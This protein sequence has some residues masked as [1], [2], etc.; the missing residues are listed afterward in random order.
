MARWC[1]LRVFL[2]VFLSL[3]CAPQAFSQAWPARPIHWIVPYAPGAGTDTT[4][5]MLV[6]KLSSALGQPIVVENRGGAGGAIGTLAGAKAP[7]DGYT[8]TFASDPPFTINPNLRRLPFDPQ[9]D[10]VAVSLL[11]KVPLVLVVK[12][13]LAAKTVA[14][15][16][17]LAR[18]E[19]GR[20]TV[21]SSGNGSSGHLAGEYFKAVTTTDILHVPYKGQAEAVNDVVAGR[22][23][24]NFSAI[25]NVLQL[26]ASGRLRIIAIASTARFSGLPE[27]PTIAESGYPGFEIAAFHGLLM[28]AGTPEPIVTRVN[29]EV[30]KLLRSPEVAARMFGLGFFPV[31]GAPVELERLIRADTEKWG[32]LISS[33][34]IKAE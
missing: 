17:A 33:S 26:A 24:M 23:D 3:A 12:P 22:V 8:W 16:V 5:R 34:G 6:D 31:G 32:K 18:A 25:G 27:L 11:A 20:L 21:S 1:P 7:P 9:K 14:E 19:P 13:T 2:A 15:L 30:T 29:A 28:P 10:F 4:A